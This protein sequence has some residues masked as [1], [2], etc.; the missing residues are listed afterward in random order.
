MV[1]KVAI[2]RDDAATNNDVI[3]FHQIYIYFF[4]TLHRTCGSDADRQA[5]RGKDKVS[6]FVFVN[7]TFSHLF[8]AISDLKTCSTVRSAAVIA[9]KTC[10]ENQLKRKMR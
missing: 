4:K 1:D 3:Q 10:F 7:L 8:S 6:V 5:G 2:A 9:L